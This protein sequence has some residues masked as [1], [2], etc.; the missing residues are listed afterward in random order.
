LRAKSRFHK[1]FAALVAQDPPVVGRPRLGSGGSV[2]VP[3]MT[4][5]AVSMSVVRTRKYSSGMTLIELMVAMIIA[6][7]LLAIALPSFNAAIERNRM[8]A[9]INEFTAGVTLARTEA[10]RRNAVTGVCASSDQA[11]CTGTWLQGWMA[12]ADANRNGAP[13]AGEA[14]RVGQFGANDTLDSAN[15]VTDMRFSARGRR[16]LPVG[17]MQLTL[18]AHHCQTGDVQSARRLTINTSG[19]VLLSRPNCT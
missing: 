2:S 7:L 3:T 17:D 8:A 19:Q 12:W 11:T 6:A 9:S 1:T 4:K 5:E 15:G 13:D 16:T 14:I 10:I 18:Q